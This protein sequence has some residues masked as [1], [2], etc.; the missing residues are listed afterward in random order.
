MRAALEQGT[1]QKRVIQDE[2]RAQEL[3]ITAVP[4]VMVGQADKA[5]DEAEVLDG[6]QPYEVLRTA[7]ERA[8]RQEMR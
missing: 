6:A 2:R 3:G 8:L 1:Y 5:L 7:V 4:T